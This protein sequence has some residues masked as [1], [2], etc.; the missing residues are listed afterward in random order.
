MCTHACM[1]K[2]RKR[3]KS[4]F[5]VAYSYG[6]KIKAAIS[7]DIML[8]INM[9][10]SANK[11]TLVTFH[12]ARVSSLRLRPVEICPPTFKYKE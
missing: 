8:F 9:Y 5:L 3:F 1:Q 6:N 4:A 2:H 7:V 10:L 12:R 11:S